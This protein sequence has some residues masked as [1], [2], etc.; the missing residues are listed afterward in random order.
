MKSF[1]EYEVAKETNPTEQL[2][3]M[4]LVYSAL[5]QKANVLLQCKQSLYSYNAVSRKLGEEFK[6]DINSVCNHLQNAI[7]GIERISSDHRQLTA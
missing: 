6:T 4:N 7:E 3:E 2:D 1:D 5:Q